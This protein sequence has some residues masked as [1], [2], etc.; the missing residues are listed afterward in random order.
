MDMVDRKILGGFHDISREKLQNI[1]HLIGNFDLII[2]PDLIKPLE[3]VCGAAWLRSRGVDKIYKFDPKQLSVSTLGHLVYLIRGGSLNTFKKVLE[4][5][6]SLLNGKPRANSD[7]RFHIIIVPDVSYPYHRVLEEDGLSTIV[8]LYRFSWDFLTLDTNLLSLELPD[9]FQQVFAKGDFTLLPCIAKSLRILHMICGKPNI[10]LTYGTKSEKLQQMIDH[11][12]RKR[13][14]T[15][16]G[17]NSSAS[18]S[19]LL[20]MDRDKDYTSTLMTPATYTGLLLEMYPSNAGHLVLGES[21]RMQRGK[22]QWF[23]DDDRPDTSPGGGV[24][25]G[26]S[27]KLNSA[28]DNTFADNKY[29]HIS[30]VLSVLSV[31]AKALGLQGQEGYSKDMKIH[32]M[33]QFVEK[34]LPQFSQAKAELSRHL[35]LAENIVSEVGQHFVTIQQ[36]EE[37]MAQ[38][39]NRK[40]TLRGI[41]ETFLTLHPNRFIA[42]KLLVLYHHT[43]D[44]TEDEMITSFRNYFNTFGF[45][46]LQ[47]IVDLIGV[48]LLPSSILNISGPIQ[49]QRLKSKILGTLPKLQIPFQVRANKLGL[50]PSATASGETGAASGESKCPSY[51]FNGNYIPVV[52]QLLNFL[53]SSQTFEDLHTKIGHLDHLNISSKLRPESIPFAAMADLIKSRKFPELLPIRPKSTVIVFIVG[54]VT[55]AEI[56]ACN[57]ISQLLGVKIIVS[58]NAI[59][60]GHDILT[61]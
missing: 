49:Q 10:V 5:I 24:T 20:L 41:E 44:M 59:I 51:V 30:E 26:G 55:Y 61:N 50:L 34:K 17:N 53:C 18:L 45:D 52:A 22:L 25:K 1:F 21:S 15:D 27:I 16:D 40:Q 42:L 54:G 37:G 7:A 12:E 58:S 47:S 32:E 28:V 46:H 11:M 13:P 35:N 43:F 23:E 38:S 3:V 6:Q 33:K 31:Q 39:K 14:S 19:A 2:E 8:Q 29:R 57:L 4:Q 9:I 36:I 60:S 56:A 48:G